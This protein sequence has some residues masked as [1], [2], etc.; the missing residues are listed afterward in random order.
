MSAAGKF[1]QLRPSILNLSY[2]DGSV[3]VGTWLALDAAMTKQPSIE[4]RVQ[5]IEKKVAKL[6]E[7]AKGSDARLERRFMAEG[8][9]MD[10][11]FANLHTYLDERFG[12][13]E[14][15]LDG[16][17]K[18]F[19]GVEKRFDGIDRRFDSIDRELKILREGMTIILAK[20]T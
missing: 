19:D 5:V 1:C 6:E 14:K 4:S 16:H 18:R 9:M 8:E 2:D 3:V 13:I 20:L 15:R 12:G 11:R 10:E 17:D 7:F